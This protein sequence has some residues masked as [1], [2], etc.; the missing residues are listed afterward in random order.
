ME[1]LPAFK[2][3]EVISSECPQ[4]QAV[5]AVV[6]SVLLTQKCIVG[7]QDVHRTTVT[8]ISLKESAPS[9]LGRIAA[10]QG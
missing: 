2:S 4:T 5:P 1:N 8:G 7:A 6:R 10:K 3:A 9:H